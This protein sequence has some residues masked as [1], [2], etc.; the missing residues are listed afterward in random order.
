MASSSKKPEADSCLIRLCAAFLQI[1][2]SQIKCAII[3]LRL[4]P[5]D[6]QV[7][8]AFTG[9]LVHWVVIKATLYLLGI[10]SSVPFLEIMAYAGYPFLYACL[11]MLVSFLGKPCCS[12]T[13]SQGHCWSDSASLQDVG[14]VIFLIWLMSCQMVKPWDGT[15]KFADGR[16]IFLALH[17]PLSQIIFSA[18]GW[19]GGS[20]SRWGRWL[21]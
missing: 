19:E 5:E 8:G 15:C 12:H 14:P 17:P 10:P 9:W 16:Q 1:S 6:V 20:T 7:S 3:A 11:G 21:P 18:M 13:Y 4:M 2:A